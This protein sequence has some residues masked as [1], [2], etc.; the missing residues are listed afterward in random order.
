MKNDCR[1]AKSHFQMTFSLSSTSCLLKLSSA[2]QGPCLHYD[3]GD[4]VHFLLSLA[5]VKVAYYSF[6]R[7]KSEKSTFSL[8]MKKLPCRFFLLCKD[9]LCSP[10]AYVVNESPVRLSGCKG[11]TYINVLRG[12]QET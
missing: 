2:E 3:I 8:I 12:H 1:N 7:F 9:V 5:N 10:G 4:A 6:I 11:A